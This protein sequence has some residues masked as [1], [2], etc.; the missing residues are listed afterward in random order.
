MTLAPVTPSTAWG[1]GWLQE[2]KLSTNTN[3]VESE[4]TTGFNVSLQH[5]RLVHVSHDFTL[6]LSHSLALSLSVSLSL[7]LSV[8][9]SL[10]LCLS[11]SL[12]LS[13][14]RVFSVLSIYPGKG[15][16]ALVLD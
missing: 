13:L 14:S 12:V 8:S 11:V 10:S 9:H 1:R 15:F 16:V 5:W 3:S 7:Y 2:L 4:N 6:S